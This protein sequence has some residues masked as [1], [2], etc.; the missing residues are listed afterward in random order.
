MTH[1]AKAREVIIQETDHDDQG[2]NLLRR[3][4]VR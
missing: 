3:R 1:D 4:R 2:E